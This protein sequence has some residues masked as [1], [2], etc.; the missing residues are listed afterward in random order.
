MTQIRIEGL[1]TEE[2]LQM[3]LQ[4]R[5]LRTLSVDELLAF[6]DQL[7]WA[8]WH[9]EKVVKGLAH[10]CMELELE[11]SCLDGGGGAVTDEH[12]Q[13]AQELGLPQE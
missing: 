13:W 6:T 9:R 7:L 11:L 5:S 2:E 10:R 1:S 8:Q 12:R 3:E 4:R